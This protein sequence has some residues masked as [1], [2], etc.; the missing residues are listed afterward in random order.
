[1]SLGAVKATFNSPPVCGAAISIID[2]ALGTVEAEATS[3]SEAGPEP[4]S[5]TARSR[6]ETSTP[7]RRPPI[8][9]GDEELAGLRV[10]HDAPS[11]EYS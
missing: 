2:G 3:D 7:L 11:S 5:F 4:N 8:E 1:L 10:T 6:I 9:I